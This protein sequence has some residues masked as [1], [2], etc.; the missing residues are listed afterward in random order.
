MALKPIPNEALFEARLMAAAAG[1]EG[2]A[3]LTTNFGC[4]DSVEEIVE[5]LTRGAHMDVPALGLALGE[6]GRWACSCWNTA[7][8]QHGLFV[9]VGFEKFHSYPEQEGIL[10]HEIAHI[11]LGHAKGREL[12][13][14]G[15]KEMPLSQQEHHQQE[16]EADQLAAQMGYGDQLADALMHDTNHWPPGERDKDFPTHPPI[17]MRVKRLRAL[18]KEYRAQLTRK[19]AA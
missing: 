18:A 4:P 12:R 1:P 19:V 2:F 3:G 7:L 9:G 6:G 16:L 5:R 14:A 10:A 8:K 13:Y 15:E 17:T 11:V